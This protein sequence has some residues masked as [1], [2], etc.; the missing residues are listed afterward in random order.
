MEVDRLT[1]GASLAR[2]VDF[3]GL[4]AAP[5]SASEPYVP[6]TVHFLTERRDCYGAVHHP[7]LGIATQDLNTFLAAEPLALASG[8]AGGGGRN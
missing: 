2:L 8:V 5:I 7:R 6:W 1:T 4:C 3:A